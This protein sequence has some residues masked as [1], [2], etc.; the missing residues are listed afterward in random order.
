[1]SRHLRVLLQAGII[2]DERTAQDDQRRVVDIHRIGYWLGALRE[3]VTYAGRA[4]SAGR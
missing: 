3:T 4:G 1:M 2:T